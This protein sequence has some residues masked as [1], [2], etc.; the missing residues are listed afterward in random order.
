MKFKVNYGRLQLGIRVDLNESLPIPKR[1]NVTETEAVYTINASAQIHGYVSD[2]ESS[3]IGK[4][5]HLDVVS[6]IEGA[7]TSVAGSQ[8]I[9]FEKQ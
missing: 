9:P 2:P 5:N 7:A 3:E 8:F 4:I 1:E 6:Q